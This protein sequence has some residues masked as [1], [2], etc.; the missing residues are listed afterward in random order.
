V[1]HSRLELCT[2]EVSVNVNRKM[3]ASTIHCVVFIKKTPRGRRI[4]E[5]LNVTGYED[6]RYQFQQ[7]A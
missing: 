7:V 6:G 3:L 2:E 1:H 5:V 4:E